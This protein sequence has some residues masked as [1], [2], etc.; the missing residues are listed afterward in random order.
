MKPYGRDKFVSGGNDLKIDRHLGK[1]KIN[2][3][4]NICKYLPRTT[5]KPNVRKQIMHND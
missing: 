2:W 1:G 4:E 3:W 5:I